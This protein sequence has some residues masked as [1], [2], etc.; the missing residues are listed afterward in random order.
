M[1]ILKKAAAAFDRIIDG[2]NVAAMLLSFFAMLATTYEV[3]MRY[4]LNHPTVWVTEITSFSL[5][6]I[7]FLA[8]PWLLKQ[9]GHVR[10]DLLLERLSPKNQAALNAVSSIL[11][12]AVCLTLFWYGLRVTWN[13]FTRGYYQFSVL[14][15]PYAYVIWVVPVGCLLLA[16]Q[17]LRSACR[18]LAI[19][20]GGLK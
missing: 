15:I 20:R 3:L 14:N 19:R 1:K 10:V 7:T 6:F 18:N 4:C 2:S 12:A 5:L 16:V 9:E 13:V 8:A 17:F 11:G